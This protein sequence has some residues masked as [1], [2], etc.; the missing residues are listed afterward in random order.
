MREF[1]VAEAEEVRVS[2]ERRVKDAETRM[3][4]MGASLEKK[5]TEAA[6]LR[7]ELDEEREERGKL[8]EDLEVG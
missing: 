3:A 7:Q 8:E 5:A 6:L 1:A 4:E 2:L